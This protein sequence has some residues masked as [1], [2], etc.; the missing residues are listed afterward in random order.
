MWEHSES[1]GGRRDEA[2]LRSK[3]ELIRFSTRPQQWQLIASRKYDTPRYWPTMLFSKRD[4][5]AASVDVRLQSR[6][7]SVLG[8]SE[9]FGGLSTVAECQAQFHIC[10]DKFWKAFPIGFHLDS[11]GTR[12]GIQIWGRTC[13]A[14]GLDFQLYGK[15]CETLLFKFYG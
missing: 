13:N 3:I 7:H 4:L 14:Q 15:K 1:K 11:L 12:Y 2:C 6:W 10:T 8:N 9:Q 5:V